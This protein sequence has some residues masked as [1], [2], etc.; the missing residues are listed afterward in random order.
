MIRDD[1]RKQRKVSRHDKPLYIYH[2]HQISRRWLSLSGASFQAWI[3]WL[4]TSQIILIG[5]WLI[6]LLFL[7]YLVLNILSL[8]YLFLIAAAE[9]L[10]FKMFLDTI[11]STTSQGGP[12]MGEYN[13]W[14]NHVSTYRFCGILVEISIL[15]VWLH[16]YSFCS[17]KKNL[18]KIRT[19][20]FVSVLPWR[21]VWINPGQVSDEIQKIFPS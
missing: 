18:E 13:T 1:C 6:R 21:S 10:L 8:C 14:T 16:N 4:T 9:M 17:E 15:F 19:G 7:K 11:M 3:E 20:F 5:R 12:H 2:L